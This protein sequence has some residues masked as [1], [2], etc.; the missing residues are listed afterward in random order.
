MGSFKKVF[1]IAGGSD[2]GENF[3]EL[4]K[5]S[6][7]IIEAYLVG[8]NAYKIKKYIN[9]KLTNKVCVN[10][11]EALESLIKKAYLRVNFIQYYFLL[12]LLLLTIIKV[13]K[14]EAIVLKNYLKILE[15]KLPNGS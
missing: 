4:Y 1:L 15:R 10:L 9:R 5:F 2:L 13:L 8:E 3:K 6:K 7:I 14:K 11:K 12:H